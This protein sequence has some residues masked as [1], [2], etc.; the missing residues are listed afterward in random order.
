[1][2]K[3][4]VHIYD[5]L[6]GVFEGLLSYIDH[7]IEHNKLKGYP[8]NIAISGGETPK[9]FFKYIKD[10][11]ADVFQWR[12]VRLF[13]VDERCV[14]PMNP[15]SNFGQAYHYL[16]K[17][18]SI[19][20][21]NIFRM[22]G[23]NEPEQE[24]IRYAETLAT[25]LPCKNN[26]PKFDIVL[27]GLGEDGHIASIF[28]DQKELLF[29]K[30]TVEVATHPETG[31]KRITLTGKT[32]CNADNVWFLVTGKSKAKVLKRII[33]KEKGFQKYPAAHVH[34]ISESAGYFL[35]KEAGEFMKIKDVPTK[36]LNPL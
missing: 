20:E 7:C 35:D 23:E 8:L 21:T 9:N 28:P 29:S 32:I 19:P 24:A 18:A 17:Y 5:T 13:W 11:Y 33:R 22:M 4:K 16:L 34:S 15:E 6:S 3:N 2:I 1:M 30:R 12:F 14:P 36:F 10:N 31:Q 25:V 26:I 27:L